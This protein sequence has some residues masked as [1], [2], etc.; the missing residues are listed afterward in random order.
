MAVPQARG[1]VST[2]TEGSE[3]ELLVLRAASGDDVAWHELWRSIEPELTRTISNPRFLGRLGQR[4]DDRRNI[5][6]ETIGRLAAND[7]RR[8]RDYIE[9]RAANPRLRFLTWLRVV[10][11]RVG[12]DYQRGHSQYLDRRREAGASTPGKWIEPG[13]LPSEL[14]G[15]RPPVTDLGTAQQVV[16]YAALA[17]PDD[18]RRALELWVHSETYDAIAAALGLSSAAEA[19]R[20]VRAAIERLRRKFARPAEPDPAGSPKAGTAVGTRGDDHE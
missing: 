8:L 13:T 12:I 17:L 15:E 20:K 2:I 3:V 5:I 14:G 7:R 4:E 10:A 6:L 11:K 1:I 16:A 9:T 18:Q 19:E